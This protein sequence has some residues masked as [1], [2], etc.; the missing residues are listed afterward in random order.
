LVASTAAT[1]RSAGRG[2][3]DC[4]PATTQPQTIATAATKATSV[5]RRTWSGRITDA[6]SRF[7]V[8]RP[9]TADHYAEDNVDSIGPASVRKRVFG[10]AATAPAVTVR[11]GT[12]LDQP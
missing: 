8:S 6:R 7:A 2:E 4:R 11:I 12:H 3:L 5:R 1:I 9:S 10:G